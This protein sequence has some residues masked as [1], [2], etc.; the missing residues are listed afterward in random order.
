LF[1][2]KLFRS[3]EARGNPL[4]KRFFPSSDCSRY[5]S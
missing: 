1:D 5:V 4:C 3:C 2:I